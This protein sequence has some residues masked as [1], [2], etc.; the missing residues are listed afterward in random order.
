MGEKGCFFFLLKIISILIEMTTPV[1]VKPKLRVKTEE[2]S[3]T[4]VYQPPLRD[5]CKINEL[6]CKLLTQLKKTIIPPIIMVNKGTSRGSN[7]GGDGRTMVLG[8]GDTRR[9]I[10]QFKKN[11]KYPDLLKY[12]IEF[13][14]AVMPIGFEYSAITVNKNMNAKKHVDRVNGGLSYIIGL[15]DF[16]GGNIIVW[17]KDGKESKD[18]DLKEKPIGFNGAI[19]YHQTAPFVGERYTLIYYKQKWEGG[20]DGYKTVGE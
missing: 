7:L 16:T 6:K 9:G 15:G 14:N 10:R 13:G 20:I 5:E 18:Y 8:F 12:L 3:D 4:N 19:L 2:F 1:Y 17:D 11:A